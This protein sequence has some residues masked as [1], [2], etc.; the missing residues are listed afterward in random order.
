MNIALI[1]ASLGQKPNPQ[2]RHVPQDVAVEYHWLTSKE[3]PPRPA[4]MDVRLQSKIPRMLGWELFPGADYYIWLDDYF[5]FV[6]PDAVRWMIEQLGS[7]SGSGGGGCFQGDRGDVAFFAHPDRHTIDDECRFIEDGMRRGDKYLLER[8]KGEPLRA[9]VDAYLRDQHRDDALYMSGAFIYRNNRQTQEALTDWFTQC[10]RWTQMCQLSLPYVLQ[11]HGLRVKVLPG[12]AYNTPYIRWGAGQPVPPALE[13]RY[14]DMCD[15]PSDIN[16]HMHTLSA[17]ARRCKRVTE[18]GVRTAVSTTA[19]LWAQPD[20]LVTYDIK[21]YPDWNPFPGMRG[22]TTLSMN[23]GDSLKVDLAPT[24]MLFIDTLHT[25]AQLKAELLRHWRRVSRYIVLHDTTTFGEKGE[26][27]TEPGLWAAVEELVATGFWK[28]AERRTNNNG[29]TVLE[30][31]RKHQV[32]LAIPTLSE[33]GA[34]RTRKLIEAARAGTLVPD[35]FFVIDNGGY[36][37]RWATRPDFDWPTWCAGQVEV[38]APGKN[39][40]VAPSWNEAL[41]RY[42]DFV[43]IANDDLEIAPGSIEALV[44]AAESSD[45]AFVGCDLE[46]GYPMF[47]LKHSAVEAVGFFDERFFPAYGEDNDM[48]Y[49]LKL[50]GLTRLCVPTGAKEPKNGH[51]SRDMGWNRDELKKASLAKYIAKWGGW[52]GKETFKEP[53]P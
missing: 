16:E 49:R 34:L 33:A 46:I 1:Q 17:Y 10:C 21:R 40:G 6:R 28:V 45:A 51:T 31:V 7:A 38:C 52:P 9:Q 3:L 30:R 15:R 26:D 35:R 5:T 4:A 8:Y 44:D 39:I 43:I 25:Y 24:D 13:K 50:A 53:R 41:R 42:P 22:R 18:L 19:L 47:I 27:G 23:V 12:N 2:P 20:S 11:R 36:F 14:W 48:E 29:L 32:T 37:G